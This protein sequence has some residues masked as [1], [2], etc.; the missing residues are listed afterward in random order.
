MS[1]A[2]DM[3][4]AI[5]LESGIVW[6][7]LADKQFMRMDWNNRMYYTWWI[8]SAFPLPMST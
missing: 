1:L 2:S 8:S 7:D 3:R 4:R 5:I 6:Q